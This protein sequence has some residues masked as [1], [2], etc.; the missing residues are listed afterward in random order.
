MPFTITLNL[1]PHPPLKYNPSPAPYPS[2]HQFALC[3]GAHKAA[4][5]LQKQLFQ[6]YRCDFSIILGISLAGLIP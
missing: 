5:E 4:S 2:M 6:L 1:S 3:T